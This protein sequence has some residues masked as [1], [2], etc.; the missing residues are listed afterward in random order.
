MPGSIVGWIADGALSRCEQSGTTAA[1]GAAVG[2][3]TVFDAASLSK[4]VVARWA[5]ELSLRGELELES[6]IDL[7]PAAVGAE[8]DPRLREITPAMVLSHSTGFPNWR[9]PGQPLRLLAAPGER[10]VYSGE[11]FEYLLAALRLERGATR[12]EAELEGL[13]ARLRMHDSSFVR[14]RGEEALGHTDAGE[15]AGVAE[16]RPLRAA[17]SL[18]TSVADYVRFVAASFW[19]AEGD[20]EGEAV[21]RL[22]S[23]A[24][25]RRGGDARTIGWAEATTAAGPVLWQNGDNPGF[26]H[27]VC[28]QPQ[29]RA[30]VIALTNA[31]SGI[32]LVRDV[33]RQLG[34]PR[35]HWDGYRA[36]VAE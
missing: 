14:G 3:A 10:I 31:D 24:Y 22:M 21:R 2:A 17:G 4:P 26:K 35:R 8:P 6:P 18:H 16:R 36:A 25:I 9:Q 1:V 13:L 27:V 5:I 33:C 34:V 30:G 29:G 32:A 7:D 23:E 11:G 15:L 19:P 12:V 20:E 28:V